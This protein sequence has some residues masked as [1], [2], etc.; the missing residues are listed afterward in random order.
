MITANLRPAF[1]GVERRTFLDS[2]SIGLVST[3]ARDAIAAFLARAEFDPQGAHHGDAFA[4]ARAAAAAL[5]GARAETIALIA[6]TSLA[7]NIAAD[8][9]PLA[10][11]DNVV[12]TDLEFMSVVVPWFEKCRA[13][14]AELRVV[15]HRGGRIAPEDVI[16]CMD[17]RTRAVTLSAVQ[18]TNGFR[19]DL[20]PI[21]RACRARDIPFV[22][23]AIQQIGVV[24]FDVTECGADFVA[25]G[26]HKWLCSP[27][28]TGFAYVSERFAERFRPS[29]SYVPTSRP[30]Q[31]NWQASWTDPAYDPIRTYELKPAASRFE[32][33]IHHAG[34]G[35]TGLAAAL[36]VLLD[37]SPAAIWDRV[38]GLAGRVADGVAA[39][40]LTVVS[41]REPEARSGI[42]VFAT[43]LGPAGDLA[44]KDGLAAAGVDVNVRYTSGIGG[45]RVSTHAYN[46]EGDVDRFLSALRP[47]L[48]G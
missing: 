42:T 48:A 26:G 10:A 12:T 3:H 4:R 40:G 44:V 20:A 30:P 29:L 13:V 32:Q 23:D 35:A 39:L 8:A 11:G 24:P 19:M 33:G 22:L 47:L 46:D 21:G 28:A 7:L 5:I 14:G 9:I 27:A 15:R 25:C 41:P 1:P 43:G 17:A 38:Q 45:V 37:A 18:W 31:A 34:L 2:A 6:S 36:G 16:A